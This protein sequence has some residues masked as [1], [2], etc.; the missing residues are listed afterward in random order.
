MRQRKIR[1]LPEAAQ[2]LLIGRNRRQFTDHTLV[3]GGR[4]SGAKLLH[5]PPFSP[6]Q[7]GSAG[8]RVGAEGG[9]SSRLSR[10]ALTSGRSRIGSP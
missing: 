3:E 4:V 1:G 7:T 9:N 8:V 5:W 2:S 10:S 6:L